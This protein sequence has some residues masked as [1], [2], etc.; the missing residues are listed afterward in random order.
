MAEKSTDSS[1][2]DRYGKYVYNM[3]HTWITCIF[4]YLCYYDFIAIYY[5]DVVKCCKILCTCVYYDY[6]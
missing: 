1:S 4:V 6:V 3:T 2:A 5:S